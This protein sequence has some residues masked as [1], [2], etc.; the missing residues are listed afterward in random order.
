[1]KSQVASLRQAR[2]IRQVFGPVLGRLDE[3]ENFFTREFDRSEP[4]VRKVAT[5][6]LNGGGKR[7][8]PALVLLVSRMLGYS[9]ERCDGQ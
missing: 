1:M 5:Y 8:R 6:V 9:G 3:V 4:M 7:L 2:Q